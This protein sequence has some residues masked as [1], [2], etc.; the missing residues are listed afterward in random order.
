MSATIVELDDYR[1]GWRVQRS[2]CFACGHRAVAVLHPQCSGRCLECA[3]CWRMTV[4][5]VTEGEADA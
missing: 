3:R 5:P 2:I 1:P 4:Q